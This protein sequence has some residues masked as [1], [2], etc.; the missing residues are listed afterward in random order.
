[1]DVNKKFQMHSP[2]GPQPSTDTFTALR[3]TENVAQSES[4][5][6]IAN[7]VEDVNLQEQQQQQQPQQQRVEPDFPHAK[8]AMLDEKISSPRWVVPVLPEQELESL[9]QA[10]IELCRKG[11][12]RES[13]L[14]ISRNPSN[15]SSI[16]IFTINFF[17]NNKNI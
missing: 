5:V 13:F 6:E 1:M 12:I 9:L 10:S 14:F 15:C 7:P 17:A 8:L 3:L 16:F 11:T 4:N 2:Q